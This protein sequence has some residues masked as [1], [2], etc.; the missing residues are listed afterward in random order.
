M[1]SVIFLLLVLLP[2]TRAISQDVDSIKICLDINKVRNLLTASERG[3]ISEQ[4]VQSFINM[5]SLYMDLSKE[6]KITF[7]SQQESIKALVN[8]NTLGVEVIRTG[9][10]NMNSEFKNLKETYILKNLWLEEE[11]R[12]L[13][14]KNA[15]K[16]KTIIVLSS[17]I[18]AGTFA[19]FIF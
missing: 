16:T 4:Q 6:F 9:F 11:R 18:T 15:N 8:T 2:I 14:K 1:K 13:E 19:A 12:I 10:S 17:I 7:I 3:K 5:D